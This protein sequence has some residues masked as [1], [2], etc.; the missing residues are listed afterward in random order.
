MAFYPAQDLNWQH[1][2]NPRTADGVPLRAFPRNSDYRVWCNTCARNPDGSMKNGKFT[3]MEHLIWPRHLTSGGHLNRVQNGRVFPGLMCQPWGI[4]TTWQCYV[5]SL[6]PDGAPRPTS[7]QISD[8][9]I[10]AHLASPEHAR[11]V[12][13]GRWARSGQ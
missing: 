6:K 9:T 8:S 2:L 11:R 10:A 7:S 1:H 3:N 12:G 4:G 5:C 13:D